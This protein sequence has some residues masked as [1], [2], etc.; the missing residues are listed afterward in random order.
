MQCAVRDIKQ[1]TAVTG[2]L[3]CVQDDDVE[4]EDDVEG[5]DDEDE[6]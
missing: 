2:I 3:H 1:A 5:E 6:G 4:R